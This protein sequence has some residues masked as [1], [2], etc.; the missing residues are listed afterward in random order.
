MAY[1]YCIVP[2]PAEVQ[3]AYQDSCWHSWHENTDPSSN[4]MSD[5][6]LSADSYSTCCCL[7]PCL[8]GHPSQW[9]GSSSQAGRTV[10]K[11]KKPEMLF[12]FFWF[13]ASY[14]HDSIPAS[15]MLHCCAPAVKARA[16]GA[17]V[18]SDCCTGYVLQP[19]GKSYP[20]IL[21]SAPVSGKCASTE[22]NLSAAREQE[23]C[24]TRHMQVANNAVSVSFQTF[25]H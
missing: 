7:C 22:G 11:P 19:A 14:A 17:A 5:N 3:F 25:H 8:G 6:L 23:L 1:Q 9:L 10:G 4:G 15:S 24:V 18:A 12:A 21:H 16:R 20:L 13:W 2:T